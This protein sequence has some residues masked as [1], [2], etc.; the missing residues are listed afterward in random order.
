MRVCSIDGCDK[1]LYAKGWCGMHYQRNRKFGSP[2]SGADQGKRNHASLED[3]LWRHTQKRGHQ[4]CWL[5]SANGKHTKYAQIQEG[6]QESRRLLAHRVSYELAYGPIPDGMVVMHSCDTP[7]CVNPAHLSVGTHQDNNDDMTRKHRRAINVVSG[8]QNGRSKLTEDVVRHIRSS[9]LR[10]VD[11]AREL[12]FSV[13]C[14]R[15][16]RVRRTWKHVE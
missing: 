7:R 14:I 11:L 5:C 13:G 15:G 2:Y 16:V 8:E 4:D 10:N 6:G 12:G 9:P 3:R 1:A